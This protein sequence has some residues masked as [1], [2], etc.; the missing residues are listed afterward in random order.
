MCRDDQG[1]LNKNWE[2]DNIR[3][4]LLVLYHS[5][6]ALNFLKSFSVSNVLKFLTDQLQNTPVCV[7][8]CVYVCVCVRARARTCVDMYMIYLCI[9]LAIAV[10]IKNEN[11][12]KQCHIS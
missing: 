9:W 6:I 12:K 1:G 5:S 7:C 3:E 10:N 2:L 4:L 8:V 11:K